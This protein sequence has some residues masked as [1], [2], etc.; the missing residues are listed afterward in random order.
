VVLT[1]YNVIGEEVVT[2]MDGQYAPGVYDIS[3]DG[4]D[5]SGRML[6]GGIYIYRIQTPEFT[7]VR[8]MVYLK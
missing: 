2:L 6:A 7:S 4:R 8:K 5:A 1:V 3:W